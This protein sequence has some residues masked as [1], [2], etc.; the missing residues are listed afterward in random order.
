MGSS[1]GGG[2]SG[3]RNYPTP[4]GTQVPYGQTSPVMAPTPSF[5]PNDP[6]A[7]A[8]GLTPQMLAQINAPPA[9]PPMMNRDTLAST[10]N[11]MRTQYGQL[12]GEDLLMMKMF[13][14]QPKNFDPRAARNDQLMRIFAGSMGGQQ[15]RGG[16]R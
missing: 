4:A 2:S 8:T 14:K 6:G 10:M 3:P 12:S 16:S 1:G 5:L 13:G 9:P 15:S 11:P 7:M